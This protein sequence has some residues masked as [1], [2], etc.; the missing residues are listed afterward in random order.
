MFKIVFLIIRSVLIINGNFVVRVIFVKNG[1]RNFSNR[2]IILK[3]VIFYGFCK[4]FKK[5]N[6]LIKTTEER[7]SRT[8]ENISISK[9]EDT[10]CSE[11]LVEYK[12]V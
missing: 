8:I 9:N 6:Y 5:R 11:K 10:S 12:T 3:S 7:N 4:S 2:I 1:A